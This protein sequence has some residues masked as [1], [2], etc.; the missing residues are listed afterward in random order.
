[1]KLIL[2]LGLLLNTLIVAAQTLNLKKNYERML[3]QM[4]KNAQIKRYLSDSTENATFTDIYDSDNPMDPLDIDTKKSLISK[5]YFFNGIGGFKYESQNN[6]KKNFITWNTYF[7][8][9]GENPVSFIIY[10]I[11]VWHFFRNLEEV[12]NNYIEEEVNCTLASQSA[13]FLRYD[14]GLSLDEIK[15]EKITIE[16]IEK[17]EIKPDFYFDGKTKVNVVEEMGST[18]TAREN[19]K[20]ITNAT[21]NP[22]DLLVKFEGDVFF[23]KSG[24]L[25]FEKR[26]SKFYI[27]NIDL[28]TAKNFRENDDNLRV[29][30]QS[31][32]SKTGNYIFSFNNE[33]T[34][35]NQVVNSTCVITKNENGLYDLECEPPIPFNSNIKDEVGIGV[36][37]N[38]KNSAINLNLGNNKEYY[39]IL[40]NKT[41]RPAL[42]WKKSSGLSGG[43]IA[44]IVIVCILTLVVISLLIIFLKRKNKKEEEKH[45]NMPI[46]TTASSFEIN[47]DED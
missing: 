8:Y 31:E 6:R 26:F 33:K 34:D 15:G 24:E 18:S 14:C 46:D 25:S 16:N 38:N 30:Q 4:N 12:K 5:T 32:D 10:Y 1:M 42:Y 29:L 36:E 37:E 44:G 3:S 47:K 17:I 43:A 39:V 7:R 21:D 2:T 22:M 11:F 9:T 13:A 19:I 35:G 45:S 20:Y 23:M 40:T 41:E 28:I 27:N